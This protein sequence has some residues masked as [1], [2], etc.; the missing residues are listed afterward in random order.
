MRG[1]AERFHRVIVTFG[2]CLRQTILPRDLRRYILK[3]VCANIFDW[4]S[5]TLRQERAEDTEWMVRAFLI[6]RKWDIYKHVDKAGH[7]P[8]EANYYL[9]RVGTKSPVWWRL[10]SAHPIFHP[11]PDN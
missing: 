2:A 9:T 1:V 5:E 10:H 3:Y 6:S 4:E 7:L 11:E 8:Y